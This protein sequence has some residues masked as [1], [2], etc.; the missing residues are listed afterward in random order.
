MEYFSIVGISFGTNRFTKWI[1][2]E[3]FFLLKGKI[4]LSS[5]INLLVPKEYEQLEKTRRSN[6]RCWPHM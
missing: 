3:Y 6:T 5:S 2:S 1:D 4:E